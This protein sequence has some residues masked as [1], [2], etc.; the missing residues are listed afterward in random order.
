[1]VIISENISKAVKILDNDGVIGFPTET[2]YGLAANIFSETALRKIF[3]IKKRPAFNPLIVH[4]K[5]F[6]EL[7]HIAKE[8]P[9]DASLLA[10]R[11]WPGPLTL[12]LPKKPSISDTIT[13]G[14][15]TVA[16]RMPNHPMALALL[17]QLDF[18]LAAPSAN[19]FGRIS[20]TTAAH[21][22][23]YFPQDLQLVLDGGDCQNGLEST[24]VGFVQTCE[25]ASRP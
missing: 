14:K 19:P 9:N 18:P 10:A 20:P 3:E 6:S 24:I 22:A 16:V 1:M 21:V 2:V 8:V 7:E 4:I 15:P 11:F 12:L 23:S 25:V 17:E 13:A 5:H